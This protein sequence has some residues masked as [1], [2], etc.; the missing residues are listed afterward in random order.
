MVAEKKTYTVL[1]NS[2]YC[3]I[4]HDTELQALVLTYKRSG[5]SE[6]FRAIHHE[7]LL[8]MGKVRVNRLLVNTLKLGAVAPED[9]RWL[10]HAMIP[11]LAKQTPALYL[12]A[13]VLVPENIF[14]KLAVEQVE[15][16][17]EAT[18]T[19]TNRHFSS[20]TEAKNWLRKQLPLS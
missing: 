1:N 15:G 20:Y 11:S 4:R 12:F 9:Q 17:S 19:C 5:A 13:A 6:E 10:G 7:L 2:T 16:I 3:E 18:G 8:L 14:T